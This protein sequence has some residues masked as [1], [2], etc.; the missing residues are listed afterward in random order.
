MPGLVPAPGT[1]TAP[2]QNPLCSLPCAFA[3]QV[4]TPATQ[5]FVLVSTFRSWELRLSEVGCSHSQLYH[6]QDHSPGLFPPS[7]LLPQ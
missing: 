2:P 3:V 4:I 6:T 5:M 7:T 1:V